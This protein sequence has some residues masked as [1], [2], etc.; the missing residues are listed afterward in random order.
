MADERRIEPF[1][2]SFNEPLPGFYNKK[3]NPNISGPLQVKDISLNGLRFSCD[4]NPDLSMTDEVLLSFI[5]HKETYSAEGR[6]IW[7]SSDNGTMTCGVNIFMFP[8]SL[9]NEI[10]RLGNSLNKNKNFI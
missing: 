5:Y 1:R 9:R 7:I 6:I 10:Y 3:L 4:E 2:Y 8:E